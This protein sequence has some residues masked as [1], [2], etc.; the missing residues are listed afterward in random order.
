MDKD[1]SNENFL[2]RGT[3]SRSVRRNS[4]DDFPSK[5]I[6]WLVNGLEV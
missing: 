2:S 6:L 1:F 3:R 4:R 5:V